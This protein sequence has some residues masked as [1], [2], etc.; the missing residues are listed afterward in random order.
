MFP[1]KYNDNLVRGLYANLTDDF[2]KTKSPA[3]GQA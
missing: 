1:K 3:F 2:A